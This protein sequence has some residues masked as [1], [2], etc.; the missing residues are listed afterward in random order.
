MNHQN[1]VAK[2]FF[3][4][5][6]CEKYSEKADAIRNTWVKQLHENGFIH[7]FLMGDPEIQHVKIVNDTLYVPC[8]D[9]YESLLLKL[10]LG[11]EYIFEHFEFDYIYKIDDDCFLDIDKFK[12][13]IL[14]HIHSKKYFGCKVNPKGSKLDTKWHYGKCTHPN[15]EKPLSKDK[16][17]F[18]YALGGFGYLLH[19][20][21][22]PLLIA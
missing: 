22:L 21:I 3:L 10:T 19:R 13:N 4:I 6:T 2:I 17:P 7:L 1:T 18:D 14:P 11:Y 9:N 5:P 12:A 8:E 15:F 20:E 16:V